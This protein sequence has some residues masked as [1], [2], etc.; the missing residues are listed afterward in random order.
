MPDVFTKAKRSEVMSRIRARGGHVAC[1]RLR[2]EHHS[3]GLRCDGSGHDPIR[4]SHDG[5]RI[6]IPVA[7]AAADRRQQPGPSFRELARGHG[8]HRGAGDLLR[9]AV[10]SIAGDGARRFSVG[11][12][13][14]AC[15]HDFGTSSRFLSF[16][17]DP[18][19]AAASRE[20]C[21]SPCLCVSV[22]KDTSP[23]A[24]LVQRRFSSA[25]L[26]GRS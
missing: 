11:D 3:H 16:L 9:L 14:N 1:L 17:K 26:C 21:F 2:H 13:W 25:R 15:V 18:S 19:G 24:A 10:T 20:W 5:P 7:G 22:V 23:E 6:E 4:S 12:L 8:V